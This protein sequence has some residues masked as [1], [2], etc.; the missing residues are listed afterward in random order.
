MGHES[1]VGRHEHEQVVV[2][3]PSD[4]EGLDDPGRFDAERRGGL[5]ERADPAVARDG[6]LDAAR[7]Q[8]RRSP[9]RAVS[10]MRQRRR[11]QAPARRAR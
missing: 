8:S 2:L 5:D 1:A 10:R 9:V 11:T 3:G 7:R 6:V 4:H